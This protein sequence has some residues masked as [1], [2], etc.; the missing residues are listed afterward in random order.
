LG[1]V[2]RAK[3]LAQLSPDQRDLLFT[4]LD[5]GIANKWQVELATYGAPTA[6][7][8]VAGKKYHFVIAADDIPGVL[9]TLLAS[10]DLSEVVEL[11]K[12]LNAYADGFDESLREAK[13]KQRP[14]RRPKTDAEMLATI[15]RYNDNLDADMKANMKANMA[16]AEAEEK[17]AAEEKEAVEKSDEI[18][19]KRAAKATFKDLAAVYGITQAE[20]RRICNKAAPTG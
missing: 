2:G 1:P 18:R 7:P 19:A 9:E 4:T 5:S 12:A 17:A 16:R 3:Q 15:E 10:L 8:P 13:A 20:V 6:P 11:H 14:P